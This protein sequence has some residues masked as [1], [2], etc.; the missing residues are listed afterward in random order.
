VERS[1][2]QREDGL[3]QKWWTVKVGGGGGGYLCHSLGPGTS[4]NSSGARVRK[5]LLSPPAATALTTGPLP[6]RSCGNGH[7]LNPFGYIQLTLIDL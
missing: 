7:K 3:C 4:G 1:A 2:G 6:P 5:A